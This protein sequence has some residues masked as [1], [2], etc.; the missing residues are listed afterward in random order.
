VKRSFLQDAIVETPK[1]CIGDTWFGYVRGTLAWFVIKH[2]VMLAVDA[3]HIHLSD[4]IINRLR[5]E[6]VDV[7]RIPSGTTGQLQPLDVLVNKSFKNLLCKHSVAWKSTE[8]HILI[9]SGKIKREH[10]HGH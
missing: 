10:Q 2:V 3:I 7:V 6:N 8:W 1:K 5:N 9:L 4:R